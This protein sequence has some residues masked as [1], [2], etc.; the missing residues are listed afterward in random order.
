MS[1][2][3][4][5][6]VRAHGRAKRITET[7]RAELVGAVTRLGEAEKRLADAQRAAGDARTRTDY[8]TLTIREKYGLRDGDTINTDSG[9]ITRA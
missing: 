7:E 1:G 3:T 6:I 5:K 4:R 9:T 2:S 8:L